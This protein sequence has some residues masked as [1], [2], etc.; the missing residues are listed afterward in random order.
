MKWESDPASLKSAFSWDNK[1]AEPKTTFSWD[2]KEVLDPSSAFKIEGMSISDVL[3]IIFHLKTSSACVKCTL[4]GQLLIRENTLLC[5]IKVL[6]TL[7]SRAVGQRFRQHGL[8]L[9]SR[10]DNLTNL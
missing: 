8:C 3:K 4:V 2:N 9:V 7:L 10:H 5:N 1:E 6:I